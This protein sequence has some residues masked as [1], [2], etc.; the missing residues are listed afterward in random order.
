MADE[1]AIARYRRW[2]RKLLG[3]YS[4]PHR[5]R[6]AESMEQTF[7]DLCRERARAGQGL[8]G[9]VLWTFVETS[10]GI[11]KDNMKVIMMQNMTRRLSV[12]A[13][14]VAAVLMIPLLGK[15]PWTGSD[16]VF[17]GVLLFGSALV[18]ELIA[19]KGG[20]TAY[21]AAVGI[22]CAAGLLLV[23]INGAVGIIGSEDNPANLLYAGVLAV[24]FIGAFFARFRPRGMF[25]ALV[26]TA[27]AQALVPVIALVLWRPNFSPGMVQVFVLNA[28]FVMLWAVSALLFRHAGETAPSV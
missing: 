23:W 19:R 22:A 6:F 25:R 18:Y 13:V 15:W 17:A 28:L 9:F 27:L 16:F 14:V 12:W 26:A 5:E 21:R 20:T 11:I 2:Y 4:R 7:N 10:A 3:F 1:H 24:G 8:L